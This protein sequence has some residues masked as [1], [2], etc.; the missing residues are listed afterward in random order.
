MVFWTR[1][2]RAAVT[3]HI[4]QKQIEQRAIGNLPV[5]AA[6]LLLENIATA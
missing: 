2:I 5:D 4:E 1:I 3:A 6:R